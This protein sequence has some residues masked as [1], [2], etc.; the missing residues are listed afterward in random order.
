MGIR[1]RACRRPTGLH[2]E[3]E[4]TCF[5]SFFPYIASFFLPYIYIRACKQPSSLRQI[6]HPEKERPGCLRGALPPSSCGILPCPSA[7]LRPSGR[8]G[9]SFR[10][11]PGGPDRITSRFGTLTVFG[12][13]FLILRHF[14]LSFIYRRACKSLAGPPEC[15][16]S[17]P[18]EDTSRR[19]TVTSAAFLSADAPAPERTGT[20]SCRPQTKE[21]LC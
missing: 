21:V 2:P 9:H 18:A 1:L 17:I 16:L 3:L 14:F 20:R 5:R 10:G 7:I 8:H 15:P 4:C 12:R 11:L 13:F 6:W 19:R